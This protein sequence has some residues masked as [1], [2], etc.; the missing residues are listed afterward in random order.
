MLQMSL[1]FTDLTLLNAMSA[2]GST[3]GGMI[4]YAA[5]A[6]EAGQANVVVLVYADAPLR[7]AK[8]AGASYARPAAPVGA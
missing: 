6:I 1:G 2:F 8:S 7:P 5:A 3:S 4:H